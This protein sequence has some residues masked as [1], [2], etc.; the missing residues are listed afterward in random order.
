MLKAKATASLLAAI[1]IG[2]TLG[3]A[4]CEGAA[5]TPG[6]DGTNGVDGTNGT[7]G[8][9]GTNGSDGVNG[10]DGQPGAP[11]QDGVDGGNGKD[12]TDGTNG[13]NGGNVAVTNFHGTEALAQAEYDS[14]GK[15]HVKATISSATVTGGVVTVDFAVEDESGAPLVG[16]KTVSA[17]IAKL[18]PPATGEKWNKWVPYIYR[19]ETVT[20]TG[21]W[22]NPVG[23]EANQG[24]RESNGTLTDNGDGTYTY[25][26]KTDIS[27]VTL[28][29][30]GTAVP[31]E[32]NRRTRVSIMFGGHTGPTAD[33]S[34]DFVP[35]GTPLANVEHRDIVRTETCK[36]C[37]GPEFHG[38]GGDRLSVEN[39]VTCHAPGSSDAHGGETIDFAVMIH[40][41]HAGG[42]LA[43]IAGPDGILWDNPATTADES[44]DNGKYAIWGY[45][46]TKLEW[47]KAG[48]PA[49]IENCAKCHDGT[50][51]DSDNWKKIVVEAIYYCPKCDNY[52]SEGLLEKGYK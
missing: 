17:S 23:T 18:V 46:N 51:A 13:K 22:K 26:Y 44:A 33:A 27:A 39:C 38:H 49:V 24:Y 3:A 9:N 50:G 45:N 34:F 6:K 7:D 19:K 4:G 14:A 32:A 10:T 11:G 35:D 20:T 30:G 5:G 15:Y 37:H 43:S 36:S 52:W 40:K 2:G 1:L 47:W 28:P 29:V 31:Y 16:L 12:G 21:E 42:E 25:V 8:V 48:F 41:I